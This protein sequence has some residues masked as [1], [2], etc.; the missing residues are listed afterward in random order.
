MYQQV[1][2]SFQKGYLNVYL[3]VKQM[4]R[5]YKSRG[6]E[7]KILIHTGNREHLKERLNI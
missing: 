2:R 1:E 4:F 5:E 3:H 7:K 6:S